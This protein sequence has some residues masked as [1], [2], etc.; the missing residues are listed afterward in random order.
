LNNFSQTYGNY[1]PIGWKNIYHFLEEIFENPIIPD[2]KIQDAFLILE[3]FL[4]HF[5]GKD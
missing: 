5:L 2:K 1:F 4:H 3:P